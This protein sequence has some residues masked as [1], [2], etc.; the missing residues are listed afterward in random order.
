MLD[1]ALAEAG[2]Y[3]AINVE[4]SISRVM[5]GIVDETHRMQAQ[6]LKQL[7]AKYS[8][9]LDLINV[10]AYVSGAD[11]ILDEAIQ[12]HQVIEQFLKQ[13]L[14][15]KASIQESLDGMQ[16]ILESTS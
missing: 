1:R 15:L 9:N 8:R 13:D 7:N 5:H 3:P 2:H 16:N 6:K 4:Q 11:P 10:G 14:N 12:K